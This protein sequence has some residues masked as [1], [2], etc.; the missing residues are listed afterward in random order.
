MCTKWR[1]SCI[2]YALIADIH[3]RTKHLERVLDHIDTFPNMDE[4]ICLGDIFE[5]K[6][7]K[8]DM[9]SKEI[10]NLNQAIDL[11]TRLLQLVE[12]FRLISGNQEERLLQCI[13]PKQLPKQLHHILQHM[14]QN[15]YMDQ[16][17]FTHGHCFEYVQYQSQQYYHPLVNEWDRPWIFYGHNHQHAMFLVTNKENQ[18]SYERQIF[19]PGEPISLCAD[20]KTLINIGDIRRST[21]GWALFDSGESTV[22]FYTLDEMNG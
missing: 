4:I 1:V 16:A 18:I 11:D 14:Y 3:G 21:P 6:I 15:I 10:K 17:R 5:V 7:S 9:N 22:T 2:R 19:E 8:K 13:P 20:K 12:G